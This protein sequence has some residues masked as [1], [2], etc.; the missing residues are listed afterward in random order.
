MVI[1]ILL[2]IGY[3]G[4]V[5]NV[6]GVKHLPEADGCKTCETLFSK[7]IEKSGFMRKAGKIEKSIFPAFSILVFEKC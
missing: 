1:R 6:F 4:L 5:I 7:N 2:G 3:W